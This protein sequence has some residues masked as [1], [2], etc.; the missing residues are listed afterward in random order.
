MKHWKSLMI[1]LLVVGLAACG[2]AAVPGGPHVPGEP[3][4]GGDG[5]DGGNGGDEAIA[6]SRFFLFTGDDVRN[7]ADPTLE[8]AAVGGAHDRMPANAEG[9]ACI[10]YG[11]ADC[12]SH[13]AVSVAALPTV[14]TVINAMLALDATGRPHALLSTYL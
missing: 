2:G 5:G 4:D 9:D 11:P 6:S 14:G 3:P 10:A 8:I 7:T 12:A 1:T 13:D